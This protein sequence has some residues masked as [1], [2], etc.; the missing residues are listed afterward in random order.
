MSHSE[1]ILK[2]IKNRVKSKFPDAKIY[3]YGSRAKGTSNSDSD[4]D[5]LILI[6]TEKITLELEN[7][8]TDP[9]YDLE[10]DL[11]EVIS[12]M[13]YTEYEWNNKYRITPFY[14]NVMSE[15]YLI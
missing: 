15:G 10:F 8:I 4:W 13:V 3:L 14:E 2:E 11:G 12:P 9:L 5:L 7:E 1:N 6:D